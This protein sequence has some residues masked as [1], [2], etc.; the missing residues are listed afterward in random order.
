MKGAGPT[1]DGPQRDN[2]VRGWP[3]G[4][5]LREGVRRQPILSDRGRPQ[6]VG[7]CALHTQAQ[8]KNS[9]PSKMMG[10]AAVDD[11]QM[12]TATPWRSDTGME[13]AAGQDDGPGNRGQ[14]PDV[15]CRAL[16][17]LHRVE[18]AVSLKGA[19]RPWTARR[20]TAT[21][22]HIVTCEDHSCRRPRRW[23]RQP[24]TA[25]EDVDPL[26]THSRAGKEEEKESSPAMKT[27]PSDRGWTQRWV[28]A[29]SVFPCRDLGWSPATKKRPGDHVRLRRNTA[30]APHVSVRELGGGCRP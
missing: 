18:G 14:S 29:P 15:D 6:S 25:R 16:A 27:K 20:W 12:W 21:P 7:H 23:A 1:D 30:A 9:S 28:A 8:G 26:P 24:R 19:K 4:E 17:R 3:G 22:P 2:G 11:H 10:Q 5:P 13:L